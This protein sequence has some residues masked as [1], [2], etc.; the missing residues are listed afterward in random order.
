MDAGDLNQAW[1]LYYL[2]FRRISKQ[3][4]QLTTLEL[5]YV[6]P[7]LLA[8]KDLDLAV[9]GTYLSGVK[10]VK[11]ASFKTNLSVMTSKQRP[12]RLGIVGSDGKDYSY[13]LKG[14]WY[15]YIRS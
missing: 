1:D 11:I 14:H 2:V 7:K 15:I 3:L 8:A 5:Q 9:P 4:P 13:L 6:S 12:R 10:V